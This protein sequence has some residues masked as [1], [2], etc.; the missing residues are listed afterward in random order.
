MSNLEFALLRRPATEAS[1]HFHESA[2]PTMSAWLIPYRI[3]SW[4][5]R[6]P[7]TTYI[8]IHKLHAEGA[9]LILSQQFFERTP[10]LHRPGWVEIRLET[11]T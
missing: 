9:C 4:P 10:S 3:E 7:A 5:A 11:K 6:G 1:E 2:M 8:F